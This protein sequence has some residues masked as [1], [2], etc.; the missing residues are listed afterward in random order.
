MDERL[1]PHRECFEQ[2]LR[3]ENESA[4]WAIPQS[5]R[6][7]I[8]VGGDPRWS[9]TARRGPAVVVGWPAS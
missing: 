6:V 9:G 1:T 7:R 3:L 8:G 5:H 4:L 2:E